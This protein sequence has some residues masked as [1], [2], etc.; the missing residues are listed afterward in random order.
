MEITNRYLFTNLNELETRW[1]LQEN[2]EVIAEVVKWIS[3]LN[4]GKKHCEST[5]T[6]PEIKEGSEYLLLV[7]FHQKE[8]TLWAEPGFEIAWDQIVLPW[9]SA[10]RNF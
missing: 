6:K 3:T 10:C 7:S 5:F 8:K 2:G 9:F 4:L 1:T